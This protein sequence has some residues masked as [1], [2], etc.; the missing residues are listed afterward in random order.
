MCF[1]PTVS[2]IAG[3]ALMGV[4]V[5]TKRLSKTRAEKLFSFFPFVF[6]IQQF[7]E[8]VLWMVLLGRWPQVLKMFSITG[9][10]AT[11]ILIW[12]IFVPLIAYLFE[13]N[14]FIKKILLVFLVGGISF[15]AIV[16][17]LYL[18]GSV[19]AEILNLRVNYF[20]SS[21]PISDATFD[22][23]EIFYLFL[24]TLPFLISS[25]KKLK[26]GGL[27]IFTA[28]I[29]TQHF[30]AEVFIS[31]WCFFAAVG[32]VGVYFYIRSRTNKSDIK[33]KRA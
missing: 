6:A 3:G 21:I 24:V 10:L 25:D 28:Y 5:A 19:G 14:K 16:F 26:I 13:R 22:V 33:L 31:V 20:I 32:S 29:L 12:P 18:G 23:I 15:S 7:F 11:A 2:F 30:Y 9:F 27:F 4:G 17:F 8:G 1:S